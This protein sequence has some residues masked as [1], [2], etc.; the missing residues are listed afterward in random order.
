MGAMTGMQANAM[1]SA[2]TH[3]HSYDFVSIDNVGIGDELRFGIGLRPHRVMVDDG[4]CGAWIAP[5]HA[6]LWKGQ[7]SIG[8]FQERT[9]KT[10]FEIIE[11]AVIASNNLG[12]R[13]EN[14]KVRAAVKAGDEHAAR[15]AQRQLD[16]LH[17]MRDLRDRPDC[18][19]GRQQFIHE[20]LEALTSVSSYQLCC[21][22]EYWELELR[23]DHVVRL[24]D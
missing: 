12:I 17:E 18:T 3:H 21:F 23:G 14:K 15:I 9:W 10:P 22:D 11:G 7:I 2:M 24:E 8:A 1:N 5:L 13:F 20:A 16:T 6:D 19:P 4:A